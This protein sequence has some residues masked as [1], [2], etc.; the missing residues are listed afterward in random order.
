MPISA[1]FQ[2]QGVYW[3]LYSNGVVLVNPSA[4]Q[5]FTVNLHTVNVDATAYT[6]LYGKVAG[7]SVSLPPHS[8]L[9]L[10]KKK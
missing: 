7:Q 9:V 10:L 3:R 4:S 2:D 8:G 5:S 6:D 1:M